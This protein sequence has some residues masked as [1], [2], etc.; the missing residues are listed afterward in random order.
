MAREAAGITAAD[1]ARSIGV[2]RQSVSSWEAESEE[3]RVVPTLEH[4]L[5]YGKV[6]AA[7]APRAGRIG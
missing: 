4:A 5:A 6:L 7:L 3:A 1:V 2:S